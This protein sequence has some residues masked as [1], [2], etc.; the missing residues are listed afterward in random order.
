M[1]PK[2]PWPCAILLHC[3]G[4]TRPPT[5][6]FTN[7]TEAG[8][9]CTRAQALNLCSLPGPASSHDGEPPLSLC[10]LRSPRRT[11]PEPEANLSNG[12]QSSW[13]PLGLFQR[14]SSLLSP[15]AWRSSQESSAQ[16]WGEG[17]SGAQG[18]GDP[19]EHMLFGLGFGYTLPTR[20]E[21]PL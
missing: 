2:M 4:W 16:L 11:G 20:V 10:C 21:L 18:G 12:S 9:A 13:A 5:S 6:I 15:Q 7:W 17:K 1:C 3:W 19:W 8:M 14:W